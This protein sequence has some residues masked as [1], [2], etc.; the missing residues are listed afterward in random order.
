MQ[1][2]NKRDTMTP[3]AEG[4]INS[5]D[6]TYSIEET[7]FTCYQM[8]IKQEFA[9]IIDKYFDMF[10]Y[11]VNSVKVPN[12]TGRTNWNFVKTIECNFE[13]DIPQMH[14]QK[15]KEIFNNGITLWHNPST[16]YN[17]SASNTIV[18]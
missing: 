3:Q 12:I 8:S 1:L 4:N 13:G 10:G 9:Q 18:S 6:V 14:L 17:Y 16:M 2:Q 15:I 5:G 11:K 7:T